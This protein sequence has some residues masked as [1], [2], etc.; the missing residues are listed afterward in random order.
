VRR[1]EVL[2]CA[3]RLTGFPYGGA[4]VDRGE[5]TGQREV[6]PSR[7]VRHLEPD[8]QREAAFQV[9]AGASCIVGS[10]PHGSLGQLRLG[11]GSS[12]PRSRRDGVKRV[13]RLGC[14]SEVSE[15]RL[16]QL[17]LEQLS[18]ERDG[19]QVVPAI[20]V[21]TAMQPGCGQGGLPA[22]EVQANHRLDG[23][24]EI[25]VA[26]EKFLGLLQPALRDAKRGQPSGRV[27][28]S[29]F[30]PA[31]LQLAQGAGEPIFPFLP[32]TRRPQHLR[33]ARAAEGEE[34]GVASPLHESHDHGGPLLEPAHIQCDL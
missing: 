24:R 13:G 32:M 21:Q 18:E 1:P 9:L 28:A 19:N 31:L 30:L 14:P 25:L 29:G 3:K 16:G 7:G 15:V 11:F 33:A 4:A 6:N 34:V 10:G 5:G 26:T 2:E 22:S 17:N 20:L 12:L 8:E 27:D 23:L